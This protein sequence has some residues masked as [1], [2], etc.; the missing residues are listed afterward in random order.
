MPRN[1]S[2]SLTTPQMRART[3][4]V[5]RRT[6]WGNLQSGT[7]LW[8]VEKAMGLKAGETVK[9]IGLIRVIDVRAER[10]DAITQ[11]DVIAEGFPDWTPEQFVTFFCEKNG[12]PPEIVV[13]RIEFRHMRI[14]PEMPVA[15]PEKV[16]KCPICD[17][18]LV[19][20][21][22]T[23]W[24]EAEAGL[25]KPTEISTEC[26]HEPDIESDEWIEWNAFHYATPYI[27]WLPADTRVLKWFQHV[28]RYTR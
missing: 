19:I 5:T 4:T 16:A 13:N 15:V 1:M 2:F 7:L 26:E 23:A 22:C 12:A 17:G 28:A 3:K 10:L 27:D 11:E 24:E 9:R 14:N 21:D 20:G 25:M 6:G 8:A 18:I